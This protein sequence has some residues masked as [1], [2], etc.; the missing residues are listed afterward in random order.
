MEPVIVDPWVNIE[1]AKREYGL[2]V[3]SRIPTDIN[4]A[5][6]VGAVAHRQFCEL[7]VVNWQQMIKPDAVLLDLKGMMPRELN[8]IRL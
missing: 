2:D 6:V 5:A 4:F 7:T 3:Q 8:P 1:E